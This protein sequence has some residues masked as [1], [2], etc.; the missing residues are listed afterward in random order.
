MNVSN[1]SGTAATEGSFSFFFAIYRSQQ[2]VL[3]LIWGVFTCIA[4]TAETFR[5]WCAHNLNDVDLID[6]REL[7]LS[8]RGLEILPTN[9]HSIYP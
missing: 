2:R 8:N 5:N 7:N 6:L 4:L 1:V 3:Q 9:L